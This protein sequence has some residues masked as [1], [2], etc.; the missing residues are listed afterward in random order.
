MKVQQREWGLSGEEELLHRNQN[1]FTDVS[2]FYCKQIVHSFSANTQSRSSHVRVIFCSGGQ[3]N[4]D[5]SLGS[6]GVDALLSVHTWPFPSVPVCI[7]KRVSSYTTLLFYPSNGNCNSF[8]PKCT[9]EHCKRNA[10]L[11]NLNRR[12][13]MNRHDSSFVSTV[14]VSE[15][16]VPVMLNNPSLVAFYCTV[17]K[18]MP[19]YKV[20]MYGSG[21]GRVMTVLD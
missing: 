4:R 10:K 8:G 20:Y 9:S 13:Y 16:L 21:G 19:W 2:W 14:C 7:P 17:C 3:S 11:M 5:K 1:R 15:H 6:E 12:Q 18:T